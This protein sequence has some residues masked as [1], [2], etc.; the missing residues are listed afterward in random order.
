MY[1]V[2]KNVIHFVKTHLHIVFFAIVSI[3]GFVIRYLGFDFLSY[4]MTCCLIPWFNEFQ[5]SGGLKALHS[6]IGD[7]GL[8]YQTIIAFMSYLN[9]DC[10]I[11]YKLLSI[12][13]DYLLAYYCSILYCTLTSSKKWSLE[14]NL[15]YTTVLFLPTVVFNSAFWGQCDSI[16]VTFVVLTLLCFYKTDYKRGFIFLGIAFAF[17]LQTIFILPF[18]ICL[19]FYREEFSISLFGLT[20]LSFW[21]SGIFAY[22]QGRDLLAPFQIYFS[23]ASTYERMYL[24]V[25]SFWILV[26]DDWTYLNQFAKLLTLLLCGVG[27]YTIL[28]K[29]QK[30]DTPMQYL[31]TATWFVWTCLLFLPAM[32]E[33]YTYLLDLLLILLTFMDRRYLKYAAI[34]FLLSL[35]TYGAYMFGNGG[36]DKWF[37]LL[38]VAAWLHYSYTLLKEDNDIKTLSFKS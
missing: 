4:D 18:I 31:G 26:G 20:V 29:K 36:L 1:T 5:L 32:H 37:V 17:K 25:A 2:E 30:L 21:L 22:I 28:T 23:Q 11:L 38:Y 7:Y 9:V 35:I 19:Y 33:R 24:N 34:S 3:L 16:Y 8:L 27:L 14:F 15:V 10:V 12:L 13:F 6:S